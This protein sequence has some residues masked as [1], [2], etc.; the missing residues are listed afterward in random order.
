MICL[1]KRVKS[2]RIPQ[3]VAN[4]NLRRLSKQAIQFQGENEDREVK[5]VSSGDH[6]SS[7]QDEAPLREELNR[8]SIIFKRDSDQSMGSGFHES[9]IDDIEEENNFPTVLP[10]AET[11]IDSV[12]MLSRKGSARF[13]P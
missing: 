3:E 7:I 5:L 6:K 13:Q 12:N 10:Y 11:F 4:S 1:D 9:M 8:S 2:N